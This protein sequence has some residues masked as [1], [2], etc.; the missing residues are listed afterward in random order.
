M[1]VMQ[2]NQCHC[3]GN[4]CGRSCEVCC[5]LFNQQPWQ[6]GTYGEHSSCEGSLLIR[7]ISRTEYLMYVLMKMQCCV[8]S[9]Q[10]L[11]TR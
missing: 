9:V 6:P 1:R 8:Y 3:E 7:L 2:E 4:T 11:W 10:L 5:P